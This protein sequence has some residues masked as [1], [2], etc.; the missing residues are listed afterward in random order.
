MKIALCT[1]VS[2]ADAERAF[3]LVNIT[4]NKLRSCL[5]PAMLDGLCLIASAGP[6]EDEFDY[7]SAVDFW[8]RKANCKVSLFSSVK[9]GRGGVT[10]LFQ[11][12]TEIE[13]ESEKNMSRGKYRHR[14]SSYNSS[15]F[16][17]Y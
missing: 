11:I 17:T 3:S 2:S 6:S 7:E 15:A 5:G 13:Q 14:L 12:A 4:K 9:R 1:S 16:G 10:P 8:H